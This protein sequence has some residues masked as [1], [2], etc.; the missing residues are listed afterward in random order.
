MGDTEERNKPAQEDRSES[1]PDTRRSGPDRG[2]YQD[3]DNRDA[4]DNRSGGG[5]D[6]RDRRPRRP[7]PFFKKK[8]CRFCT[9]DLKIDYKDADLLR[10]FVTDRG[11]ILPRRI[12]GTCAKHQRTISTAIKRARALAMLPFSKE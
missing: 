7:K 4:R 5:G 8:V 1:R 11:K 12:T 9:Q 6:Y 10:R 2:G 3:R